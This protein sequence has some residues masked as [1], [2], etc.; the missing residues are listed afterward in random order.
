MDHHIKHGLA[1]VCHA[2][3][4]VAGLLLFAASAITR[5][6][7]GDFDLTFGSSGKVIL[8]A[9][10]NSDN[11]TGVAVQPDGK[12]IV[13]GYCRVSGQADFC[14]SRLN[15]DGSIDSTFGNGGK[16][17][18]AVGNGFDGAFALA[19]QAD[20]KILVGGYCPLL[21]VTLMCIVRYTPNGAIDTSFNNGFGKTLTALGDGGND[22]IYALAVQG[23][24][25]I[26]ASGG[27]KRGGDTDFC[28]VRYNAD[29]SVDNSFGQVQALSAGGSTP[30][31]VASVGGGDESA[32][33]VAIDVEGRIVQAGTCY[34]GTPLRGRICTV[35]YLPNGA[36]DS[37]F[38]TNGLVITES[39]P[40]QSDDGAQGIA[41]QADGKIVLSGSC[42]FAGSAI[43]T[44]CFVRYNDNGSVDTTFGTDGISLGGS[45]PT[46][47]VGQ[48]L[49]M[50]PDGN[51]VAGG[52]CDNQ[53][54]RMKFCFQRLN[55]DGSEEST[56]AYTG[57][58]RREVG[59]GLD[60]LRQIAVQP[61]GKILAV[62]QCVI[63]SVSNQCIVRLVGGPLGYQNCKPDIDGDGK[64]LATTDLLILSRIA[65]GMRGNS[66]VN[67]INFSTGTRK[68]WDSIRKYLVTQCGMNL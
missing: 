15:R 32:S 22:V 54:G 56:F 67:G 30:Y 11:A 42:G 10:E 49:V 68:S 24:G 17:T 8:P 29:G 31:A 7:P 16:I 25:R 3:T 1:W 38:G 2:A 46:Y 20:G 37:S 13:S 19:L 63:G 55:S 33:A 53:A 66:V 60:I 39:R 57:F 14:V 28:A 23:D 52:A 6:E 48:S 51:L 21:G 62:G 4:L 64:V 18:T 27:C 45:G 40:G 65:S 9:A 47:G 35:R 41:I 43:F 5:A 26:I 12:I 36:R 59:S 61:D 58:V 50:Q 34:A 44:F